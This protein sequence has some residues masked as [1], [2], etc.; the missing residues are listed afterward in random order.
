MPRPSLAIVVTYFGKAPLWLPAFLLSCRD[1]RD[2]QWFLYADFEAPAPLPANVT[3][4]PMELGELRSRAT[5]VFGTRIAITH[6]RKIC[7]LKPAYGLIFADDL[8]PFDFW[9]CSDLD[10]VWGDIRRFVTD[11]LLDDYDIVSSRSERMSGHFTL[12]RNTAAINRT[13]E[14]I[15][16]VAQAMAEPSYLRL[17]EREL[18]R[19]VRDHLRKA[20]RARLPASPRVYWRDEWTMDSAY[21]KALGDRPSD[22]LWWRQGRTFDAGGHELMYL[23]FHKLKHAMSRIDFGFDAAPAAFS[24]SRRG[25]LVA[26]QEQGTG[27]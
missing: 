11:A 9:A 4:R 2:I 7:D 8:Q 27:L 12:F 23:H 19:Y 18:T 14:L 16:D 6:R 22:R 17:D 21:Q 1:N 13:F 25:F 20:H 26:G 5:D 15:P 3:L 10:I 24:I